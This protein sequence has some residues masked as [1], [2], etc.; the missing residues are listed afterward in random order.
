[1][2]CYQDHTCAQVALVHAYHGPHAQ[3]AHQLLMLFLL[4][5]ASDY[6]LLSNFSW[7]G[8]SKHLFIPDRPTEDAQ[9]N[10]FHLQVH[11][12]N[13]MN[14]LELLAEAGGDSG[15]CISAKSAPDW[16]MTGKLRPW[17]CLQGLQTCRWLSRSESLLSPATGYCFYIVQGG[18]MSIVV[19][20]VVMRLPHTATVM[21]QT[22]DSNCTTAQTQQAF[23]SFIS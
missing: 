14:V 10:C 20:P 23:Q 13:P 2:T 15:S 17:S 3:A 6:K 5:S 21:F 9:K 18:A 7:G 8:V 22:T 1:M 4:F 16:V 12:G 11:L 19:L